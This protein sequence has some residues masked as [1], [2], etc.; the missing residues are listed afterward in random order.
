MSTDNTQKIQVVV[1]DPSALGLFGLAMVTLVASTQKLGI[2]N[3]YSFV[4]PWAIFLGSIAQ[5]MACVYDFK[6]NNAFGATVFGAYGLFW[7]AVAISWMI[8]M[9]VFGPILA[10]AADIKQ[11]GFAFAGYLIF[12]IFATIAAVETNK[13]LFVIMILI[14]VLFLGLALDALGLGDHWAHQMAAWAELSIS[15]LSF[16]AS[17]ANFLNKFF[18]KPF[19]PL[20]EP[21]GIFK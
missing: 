1:S 4:I 5:M 6:H 16:Y 15:M 10:G 18:G 14:D 17:G 3:G 9:G 19:L 13:T 11:L 12:S 20:G 2:T 8:K 7:S 21:F